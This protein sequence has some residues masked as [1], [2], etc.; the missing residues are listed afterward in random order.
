M[1][2]S[3]TSPLPRQILTTLLPHLRVAAA[4]AQTIQA[5]IVEQ[6]EKGHEDGIFATALTDADL[7]IQTFVEVLLL[8][9]FPRLRFYGEEQGDSFNTKYFRATDF[10]EKGDY[11]VTLDPIDGTRCYADGHRNYQIILNV[12]NPDAVEASLIIQPA[13]NR[14]YYGIRGEGAYWGVLSDPLEDCRPLKINPHNNRI[15]LGGGAGHFAAQISNPYQAYDVYKSYSSE[16]QMPAP[17]NILSSDYAGAILGRAHL[18][19]GVAISFLAQEA[20]CIV[21]THEGHPPLPLNTCQNHRLPGLL[22]APTKAV[23]HDLCQI[24][25]ACD[26]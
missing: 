24:V 3:A 7:S 23:H 6:P 12:L 8:G 4:Y 10:G 21:T 19:D 15:Y 2:T 11:L 17:V 5:R 20:G 26:L 22:I 1:I 16:I 14:Y 13:E 9:Y 18:L 25:Q